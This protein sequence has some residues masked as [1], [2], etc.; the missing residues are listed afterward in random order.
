MSARSTKVIMAALLDLGRH[1]MHSDEELL[2]YPVSQELQQLPLYPFLHFPVIPDLS[3]AKHASLI[4]T[5]DK[6]D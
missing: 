2:I 3:S 4:C 5:L 6:V 1:L